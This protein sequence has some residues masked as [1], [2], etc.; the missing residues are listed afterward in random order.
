MQGRI[1]TRDLLDHGVSVFLADL[2][3]EGAEETLK[4]PGTD[5]AQLDLRDFD[6]T[7]Q[8]IERVQPAAVLNCAEG[9]WNFDVYRACLEAGCHVLDLG[10]DIPMTKEQLALDEQFRERGLIAITGCGSTPGVNNVL[11][12]YAHQLFDTLETVEVGFAWDSNI[13]KF[14]VPFS[15]QSII[16]EFTE[17]APIVENGEVITKSPLESREGRTFREIGAQQCFLVRH[18]E[19]Y[20]FY[21]YNKQDGLRNLRFY[22]GFPKHSA[23]A[24]EMFIDT[25]LGSKEPVMLD[26]QRIVP[27]EALAQILRKLPI[28]D[29]YR[30]KENLWVHV[31]GS[32]DGAPKDVLM[33]C[34]VD[35]LDGWESAGCNIDTGIPASI[36]TRMVLNGKISARGSFPPGR[37]VPSEAFFRELREYGMLVYE[38][39]RVINET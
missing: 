21:E 24:I 32:K 38:N 16:E 15:I 10:S 31:W 35:T 2:Y 6:A 29:G 8:R 13:K 3:R 36:M 20:T 4:R 11:L 30:E 12:H 19:T 28:P 22:A 14:V 1:A 39:G 25:G 27:I 18:P 17:P 33:E 5:F 23:E 34:I 7:K 9:N 26:G 37:V